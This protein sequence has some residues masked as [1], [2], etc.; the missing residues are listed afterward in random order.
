MG[1]NGNAP[2]GAVEIAVLEFPGNQFNGAIVP[3]LGELVDDG[4]VTILDLVIVTRDTEGDIAVIELDDMG[5]VE[6]AIFED[7]EGEA[8]GLLSDD[9]VSSAGALLA[10]GSTAAVI[11]WENSWARRLVGA[12]RDAGGRLVAHDRLDADTVARALEA[13]EDETSGGTEAASDMDA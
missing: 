4:I 13:L 11:V 10:P 5:D 2:V 12:I 6:V 9:D 8:G 7:L 1:D 3:A